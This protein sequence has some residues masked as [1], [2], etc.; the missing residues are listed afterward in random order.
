LTWKN[1]GKKNGDERGDF[2]FSIFGKDEIRINYRKP[3]S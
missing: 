1:G 3:S 2:E